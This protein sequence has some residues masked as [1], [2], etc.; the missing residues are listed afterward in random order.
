MRKE[1]NRR[2]AER[3][4]RYEAIKAAEEQERKNPVPVIFE[5]MKWIGT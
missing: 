2:R 3:E 5:A 1:K 4:Q